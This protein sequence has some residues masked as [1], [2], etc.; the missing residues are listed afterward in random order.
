MKILPV[1]LSFL[2]LVG[3]ASTNMKVTRLDPENTC[4]PGETCVAQYISDFKFGGGGRTS[5]LFL[6][7]GQCFA[8]KDGKRVLVPCGTKTVIS[9]INP[10]R[11]DTLGPA[12]LGAGAQVGSAL[13]HADAIRYDARRR[14]APQS[15]QIINQEGSSAG[16][17][18]FTDTGVNI[19]VAT[20]GCDND[21]CYD[22]TQ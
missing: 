10:D 8:K 2:I 20:G 3:C 18:A 21:N 13:I 7:G 6:I 4:P 11:L 14:K 5:A 22:P 1:I 16:A 9:A 12:F 17:N 19:G 15:L